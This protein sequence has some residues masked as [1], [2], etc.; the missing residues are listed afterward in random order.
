MVT[1][2][3]T[4][5]ERMTK[6]DHLV[7][8]VPQLEPAVD[9]LREQWGCTVLPGGRHPR[10]GTWNALV[11]LRSRS[12]LEII[13]P[14]PEP[15]VSGGRVFDLDALREPRLVTWAV[16]PRERPGG[17]TAPSPAEVSGGLGTLVERVRKA[18]VEL[19]EV[20][21]GARRTADGRRLEWFLSDPFA[22]RLGGVV[23]FLIAWGETPHP[24]GDGPSEVVLRSLEL[25][26]PDP[27]A[28]EGALLALGQKETI[29]VREAS[30][31]RL[32]ALL[33]TPRGTVELGAE[34]R[35]EGR[36]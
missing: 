2:P 3:E 20:S 11:P 33:D 6:L 10:W 22:T 31:P 24:S 36:R 13:A 34:S 17:M 18:G 27:A 35:W 28:V 23:P 15:P 25:F 9:Q 26:H 19:G 30:E 5:T 32:L 8:A 7:W 29:P 4:R 21:R 14:H 12:Y 16:R 1:T